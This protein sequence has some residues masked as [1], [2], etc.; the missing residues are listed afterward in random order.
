MTSTSGGRRRSTARFQLIG[1]LSVATCAALSWFAWMG[2]DTRYQIDPI[3]QVAR[4][5]YEAWQVIGCALSLVVLFVGALLV[6]VRPFRASIALTVAFTAA[7]TMTAAPADET[8]MY[9]VGMIMLLVGL[10]A[11]TTVTSFVVLG[12][13]HLWAA[14]RPNT[15]PHGPHPGT[16]H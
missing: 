6:G 9:G 16:A 15:P 12:I 3:T 5:P 10:A 7:W 8:G 13:R 1:I 4:G 14:R 2:W 11:A